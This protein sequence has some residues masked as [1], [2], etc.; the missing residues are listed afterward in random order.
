[1]SQR[2]VIRM[3][4]LLSLTCLLIGFLYSYYSPRL[5][6]W[7]LLEIATQS[8]KHLHIKLLPE[9][10]ELT[11]LPLGLSIHNIHMTPQP[12][13]K[14]NLA[15]T[16]IDRVDI[17]FQLSPLFRKNLKLK[18][19][20]VTGG[21]FKYTQQLSKKSAQEPSQKP[22]EK[23]P[24]KKDINLDLL[25][26]LP[27]DQIS[28]ENVNI[29]VKM[30]KKE[31]H[32]LREDTLI[33]AI[34]LKSNLRIVSGHIYFDVLSNK[35]IF[36]KTNPHASI[37]M[38]LFAQI[39]VSKDRIQIDS[40]KF[41]KNRSFFNISGKISGHLNQNQYNTINIKTE[42]DIK[43]EDL[44]HIISGVFPQK[45]IPQMEGDIDFK[46]RINHKRKQSLL[47]DIDIKSQ[48]TYLN[49]I[50]VGNFQI[51]GK[52]KGR[53]FLTSFFR[54][55]NSGAKTQ[56]HNFNI[57]L[58]D[59]YY[60]SGDIDLSYFE[61]KNFLN[62]LKIE[63][64]LVH[65]DANGN[66]PCEGRL[67]PEFEL[68]CHYDLKIPLLEVQKDN[69]SLS[70]TTKLPKLSKLSKSSNKMKLVGKL[71]LPHNK[72][73]SPHNKVKLKNIYA[74]GE[75]SISSKKLTYKSD[76]GFPSAKAQTHGSVSFNKDFLYISH[77]KGTI[78]KLSNIDNLFD[79]NLSGSVHIKGTAQGNITGKP[80]HTLI[81][82]N[83]Q[84]RHGYLKDWFLGHPSFHMKYHQG[85]LKFSDL[86][87]RFHQTKYHGNITL[88]FLKNNISLNIEAP[89]LR[90]NIFN[91]SFKK[92]FNINP[93]LHGSGKAHMN[94]WGPFSKLNYKLKSKFHRG[95][96]YGEGFDVLEC[97]ISS[98]SGESS[99]DNVL[100]KRRQSSL[101][102]SGFVEHNGN[103]D[104]H[105]SG[106]RITI[107]QI[108]NLESLGLDLTGQFDFESKIQGPHQ[109]L[110]AQIEGTISNTMVRDA[111]IKDSTFKIHTTEDKMSGHFNLLGGEID[112]KFHLPLKKGNPFSLSIYTKN[113]D[114][115]KFFSMFSES[116]EKKS[117]Q[118]KMTSEINLSNENGNLWKSSGY[119]QISR[120]EISRGPIFMYAPQTMKIFFSNGIMK[121]Q[122]FKIIGENTFLE[123]ISEGSS[124]EKINIALNGILNMGLGILI[125]PF[126]NELN[127][128]LT[129]SNQIS[130]HL[131]DPYIKGSID[132]K[133]AFIQIKKFPHPLENVS[134][135]LLF[136][137]KNLLINTFKANFARGSIQSWGKVHFLEI[138]KVPIDIKAKFKGISLDVPEG[139]HTK[140]DGDIHISGNYFPYKVRGQ[141]NILSGGVKKNFSIPISSFK[142]R[143][144]PSIILP[145]FL[146][147]A[148]ETPIDL[149][150][151]LHINNP[152]KIQTRVSTVDI[153]TQVHGHVKVMGPYNQ[154]ILR[155][156]L[157]TMDGGEV[158][159]RSNIFNIKTGR[160]VYRDSSPFDPEILISANTRVGGSDINLVAQGRPSSPE[161]HLTSR[162]PMP[163]HE[164]ISLLVFGLTLKKSYT[165][166]PSSIFD[167]NNQRQSTFQ[168]A[169]AIFNE[170]IGLT[171]E[172]NN[173]L[174]IQVDIS[175]SYDETTGAIIPSVV[176]RKQWTPQFGASIA[177]TIGNK[178]PTNLLRTEYRINN[179][180]S[181]VGS[182]KQ[183]ENSSTETD[184]KNSNI[185]GL[186]LEYKFEFNLDDDK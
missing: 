114:F 105:L 162:P 151:A 48:N 32:N 157:E 111:A 81:D 98:K 142:K 147:K 126:L 55:E 43:L 12:P 179:N 171:K 107:E 45:T 60:F 40:I 8:Q 135:D 118:S 123:V 16:N 59:E 165:L 150:F 37:N 146:N 2:T 181:F 141:Y 89:L 53:K 139:V 34:D 184:I 138:N 161:I 112:S 19:I 78:E 110:T 119:G 131:F 106:H 10:L 41:T 177:R 20:H 86:E 172:I 124:Y 170:Q 99:L 121:T 109:K 30:E 1:M 149:K 58:R 23:S 5:K 77:Y 174:G 152:I 72:I 104:A 63:N 153:N 100:I 175:S 74:K 33:Q 130:G 69:Y 154:I 176:A 66:I 133:D 42:G 164:I 166:S 82:M 167:E 128:R 115:T 73:K 46:V 94:L 15:P 159:F 129:F 144:T 183:K 38:G 87:G 95:S 67:K 71:K 178:E 79:L 186:D 84:G 7:L 39:Q 28:T 54:I 93:R 156:T 70:H 116:V 11:F 47:L 125:T 163:E 96:L 155:G 22:S 65:M 51:K 143:V 21:T 185:F 3:S 136:S 61:L 9:S 75:V 31:E 50:E 91:N 140:G 80:K 83:L 29:Y 132:I 68:N 127:G 108:D 18:H 36:K 44:T 35:V 180:V 17:Y 14:D 173:Q 148:R 145:D 6:S 49:K 24:Q 102:L 27:I 26:N 64:T 113:W 134:A 158:N 76:I 103:I 120:F 160:I 62:T 97:H 101:K 137:K 90:L 92:K 85:I 4:G 122:N 182:F 168:A 56:I 52:N 117:F 13:L 88:D 25:L 169:S 57:L